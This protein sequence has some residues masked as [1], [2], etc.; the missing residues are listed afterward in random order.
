M[1]SR[2]LL[3]LLAGAALTVFSP[4]GGC[5]CG[6]DGATAPPPPE[7]IAPS[8]LQASVTS[9][10]VE[11]SWSDNSSDETGFSLFRSPN[12]SAP[13]TQ[14]G[15]VP[16]GTTDFVDYGRQPQATA[17]YR[18]RPT[19]GPNAWSSSAPFTTDPVTWGTTVPSGGLFQGRL[20]HSIIFDAVNGRFVLFGGVGGGRKNDVWTLDPGGAG[21]EG[22]NPTGAPP[23]PRVFH[24]AIYDA[25]NQR[26]IVFGGDE[27][28]APPYATTV[29]ALSLP[30]D[31]G[32]PAWSQLTTSGIVTGRANHAAVY[33]STRQRMLVFGGQVPGIGTLSDLQALDLPPTG[34]CAWSS[35]AVSFGPPSAVQEHCAVY[36]AV[37]DRLVVQGGVDGN[38]DLM[39]AT[40]L[41][42]F[43]TG[44]SA[45]FSTHP[46]TGPSAR[47]AAS[48]VYDA[49]NRRMILFGGSEDN[50]AGT[51]L[52]DLWVLSLEPGG[53]W[54]QAAPAGT[55]PAGRCNAGAAYDPVAERMLI[56][57]GENG[58]DFTIIDDLALPLD[59]DVP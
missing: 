40:W 46:S 15:S 25:A 50:F 36:D 1:R 30:P 6:D 16:A 34:I 20:G 55:V 49:R 11:L 22:E 42:T 43:P 54:L 18:V 2:H 12:G 28:T 39:T 9:G 17:H 26:M 44:A 56:Y 29:W 58:F 35:I 47:R 51:P 8:G 14:I 52:D 38:G 10:R 53:V 45:G 7:P 59:L 33:D 4:L 31:P 32:V 5:S 41:M 48:A 23:P 24:T 19:N 57:G 3:A 13:W 27:G 21:W 37:L